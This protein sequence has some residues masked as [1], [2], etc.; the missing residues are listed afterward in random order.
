MSIGLARIGQVPCINLALQVVAPFQQCCVARRQI[1]DQT[2]EA[3]PERIGSDAG[4]GQGFS[5]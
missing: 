3:L 2:G 1:G 4:A 5:H